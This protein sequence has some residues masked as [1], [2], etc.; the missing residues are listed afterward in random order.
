MFIIVILDWMNS[1][2]GMIMAL[3][4][5]VYVAATIQILKVNKDMVKESVKLREAESRPYVVAYLEERATGGVYL[6]IENIGKSM[7][8]NVKV[9]SDI[10]IKYPRIH[11][12][13]NSYVFNNSFS[14]APNQKIDFFIHHLVDDEKVKE[15]ING[16]YPIYNLTMRYENSNNKYTDEN[17]VDINI[18]K[19]RIYEVN[20]DRLKYV[21]EELQEI[22]S[23]LKVRQ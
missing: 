2:N 4:T 15:D 23:T 11:Q 18:I 19:Q 16:L 5:F 8:Y 14:L 22:K 1:N 20:K 6:V 10:E 17:V 21:V 12:I 7:A 9:S 3:L 13:S